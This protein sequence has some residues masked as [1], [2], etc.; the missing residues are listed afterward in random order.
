MPN[1]L[2]WHKDNRNPS[3]TETITTGGGTPYD[4]SSSTVKF[5]M[6]AV[7]SASL[8]VDTAATIVTPTAGTVRY[9]WLAADVDTAGQYLVWWEVTTAAKTQDMAE[10]VI[11][12]RDHAPLTNT[13]VELEQFKR[14]AELTGTSYAD[15]DIQAA[16]LAAS[17]AVDG[18]TDRRFYLD[19]DATQVRYYTPSSRTLLLV[20]DLVTL[21][22]LKTDPTGDGTYDTTWTVNT[23]FKLEPLNA[24]AD[25]WP[26][27]TIRLH[28]NST[29]S[30]PC[31]Y[32]GAVQ[33]TGRFGW[34]AVPEPVRDA[35]T[36]LASR[37][38]KRKR[39]APFGIVTVGIETGSAVRIARTDPDV[40]QLLADY[41]R[42]WHLIG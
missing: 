41:V 10:A 25:G 33:V 23:D 24:A 4:L 17:R 20:D 30:W 3:I 34:P 19:T 13:Y 28:P 15:N 37:L 18:I 12:I 1:L 42:D 5:K 26:Y 16:L 35:T 14:T 8:V 31:G 38:V 32:P 39:E 36:M 22:T 21:T 2:V 9:D 40:M 6:R 29:R 7:N 11:E 27:E